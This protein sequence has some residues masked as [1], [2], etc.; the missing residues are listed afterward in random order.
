MKGIVVDT[1]V[2]IDFFNEQTNRQVN[3]LIKLLNTDT[4]FIL[5]VVLQEVLQGFNNNKSLQIA[6]DCMLGLQFIT[7]DNYQAA[8][9]AASLYQ[10]IRGK[11]ETIRKSNDC[12]IAWLCIN[13][14]F[15][16]LHKDRDFEKIAVHSDLKL[17]K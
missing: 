15:S 9:G 6:K 7:Y 13:F 12:L 11:G 14:S 16:L 5:P 3:D 1:S 8:I 4:L 17:F 10:T 2:W